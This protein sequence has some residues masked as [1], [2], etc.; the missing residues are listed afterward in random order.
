MNKKDTRTLLF[1]GAIIAAI[2]WMKGWFKRG[3][4]NRR[5]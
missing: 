1:S 5:R 4:P 3:N 2:A